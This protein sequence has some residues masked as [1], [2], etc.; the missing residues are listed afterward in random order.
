MRDAENLLSLVEQEWKAFVVWKCD[1][2]RYESVVSRSRDCLKDV[3]GCF[4]PVPNAV[5][6]PSQR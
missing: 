5:K 3:Q 4:L 2:K 1:P 6:K